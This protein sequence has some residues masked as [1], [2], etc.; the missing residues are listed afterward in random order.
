MNPS[1]ERPVITAPIDTSRAQALTEEEL[2]ALKPHVITL[3]DG[4]LDR[5]GT[6]H[7]KSVAHYATAEEDLDDIFTTH[8]PH[9]IADHLPGPVPIVLYA[10]GGLVDEES[11][12]AIAKQQI[13]WWKANGVYPIFFV[14]KS[15]L[16]SALSDAIVR[17]VTGGPRGIPDDVRNWLVEKAARLL[18]GESVWLDMKLDAVAS[19]HASG[20]ALMFVKKLGKWMNDPENLDKVQ[21]HAVGHSAGSIFHSHLIPRA[22]EAGVTRFETVSF[23]A[24]AVRNDTFRTTLLPVTGQIGKLTIFTMTDEFERQDTCLGVYGKSLLYLISASFEQ[25]N[26]TPILGL[27][28]SLTTD[29]EVIDFFDGPGGE[30]VYSPNRASGRSGS[31]AA[32]HGG[33][34]NDRPTM[35][36]VLA[37]VTD[38]DDFTPFPTGT[39][40]FDPWIDNAPMPDPGGSRSGSAGQKRALCVGINEYPQSIDRLQ[41]A[42]PDSALWAATLA[43]AGFTV[44]TLSDAAATREQLMGS[45]FQLVTSASKGDILVFQYAGHGTYAPDHNGDEGAE[46]DRHDEALCPVDFRAGQLVLDDDLGQ[47]WDLLPED[48]SLTIFFD[49]CYSGGGNRNADDGTGSIR[50]GAELKDTDKRR[51]RIARGV[52]APNGKIHALDL[53]HRSEADSKKGPS[54]AQPAPT[55]KREVLFAACNS[56]QFAW[57]T[58]GQGDFTRYTA[59]LLA[60]HIGRVT[61]EQFFNTIVSGFDAHRQEPTFSAEPAPSQAL[62]LAFRPSIGAGVASKNP[63]DVQTGIVS[64]GSAITFQHDTRDHAIATILRGVADLIDSSPSITETSNN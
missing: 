46:N 57:E 45:L 16:G 56:R 33:F 25:E 23:L 41:G 32:S 13:D 18:G 52:S 63:S 19:S 20:G 48:V 60:E 35:N 14:W 22:L 1:V 2:R 61:N 58:N 62:L 34:D 59:P 36:S 39:P 5:E 31:T 49:S 7:P 3:T 26:G 44:S 38:R 54:K 37:L 9:F 15:G 12:F 51:F 4:K 55:R 42:V 47:L 10:H 21:V 30:I 53:L 11:G 27:Q 28:R 29:Q 43:N 64:T 40:R 17:W 50:R 24:P 8:L 6:P